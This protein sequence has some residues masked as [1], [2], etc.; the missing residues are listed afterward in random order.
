[1][2]FERE[3]KR[4][5]MTSKLPKESNK[6]NEPF[7]EILEHMNQF[8]QER[9][10]KG[11]LQNIDDFFNSPFPSSSIPVDVKETDKEYLIHAKLPGVRKEQIELNVLGNSLSIMVHSSEELIEE[12]AKNQVFQ[13]KRSLSQS[14]RTIQLPQQMNE[15]LVKASYQNGLLQITIPKQKGSSIIIDHE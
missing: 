10:L 8:F 5:K 13:K 15:K 14:S 3:E 7:G 6:K 4:R 12:D 1:V 11:L 2:I 9:P